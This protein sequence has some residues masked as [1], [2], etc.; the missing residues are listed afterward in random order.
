MVWYKVPQEAS[1][2]KGL[3]AG[4]QCCFAVNSSVVDF[5]GEWAISRWVLVGEAR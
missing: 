3:V 5:T 1:H 2:M 4:W